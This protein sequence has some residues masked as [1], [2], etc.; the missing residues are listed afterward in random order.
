MNQERITQN[1]LLLF[2]TLYFFS[3]AVGFSFG[4]LVKQTGYDA[5]IVLYIGALCGVLFAFFTLKL[6]KRRP[7]EYLVHYGKEILPIWIHVPFMMVL[8]FFYLHLGAYILREYEDFMVQTYLPT[9]PGVAVGIIFGFVIAIT[10]RLGIETLFRT[11]QGLFFIILVAV[12]L[13]NF[14]IGNEFE[15]DRWMAFVTNHQLPGFFKGV[16]SIAP[17]F[18]EVVLLIFFFP[19]I[20]ENK[21]T[22]KSIMWASAISTTMLVVNVVSILFLF[23]PDLASHLTYPTLEMIRYIHIADFIENFDPLM[24]AIWSTTVFLKVSIALYVAVIIFSQLFKLKDYRPLT[25]SLAMVMITMSLQ[26]SENTAELNDFFEISWATF[27]Y[28]VEFI[29]ILYLVVDTIKRRNIKQK[30]ADRKISEI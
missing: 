20:S 16:Y 10:V 17:W 26:M 6:A 30:N 14:F 8:F 22:L 4:P 23:G 12:F 28:F 3:T 21:K 11:A 5:W 7:Y 15:W 29:P 19:L 24:V 25:F 1:Q 13:Q 27:A 9:T 18:G 2:F